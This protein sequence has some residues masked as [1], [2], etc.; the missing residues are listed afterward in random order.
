MLR[1]LI[2]VVALLA[3]C[4]SE[5]SLAGGW[6]GTYAPTDVVLDLTIT[7]GRSGSFSGSGTFRQN[8]QT[9]HVT[10]IGQLAQGSVSADFDI[11]Y[12]FQGELHGRDTLI[13]RMSGATPG[14]SSRSFQLVRRP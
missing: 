1:S 10:V 4:R 8:L 9:T 12:H 7:Q 5:P 13:G 2:V 6:R 3:A 14:A 11:G